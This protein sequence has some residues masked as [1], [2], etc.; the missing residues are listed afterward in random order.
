MGCHWV[1][2]TLS[3]KGG[4]RLPKAEGARQ[5]VCMACLEIPLESVIPSPAHTQ[6]ASHQALAE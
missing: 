1:E 3:G 2:D 4:L 5:A 6:P